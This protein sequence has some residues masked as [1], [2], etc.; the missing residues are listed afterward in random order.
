MIHRGVAL[1]TIAGLAMLSSAGA[2]D[3]QTSSPA[4]APGAPATCLPMP[5]D[6]D[7]GE[8]CAIAE[9]G[10]VGL[11][12][13]HHFHFAVYQYQNP[14]NSVL[15][16]TRVVVFET[17]APG[18]VRAV[19]ATESDPAVS[20]DEPR[21]LRGGGRVLLHIPGSESGTGN[22]NRE[23]LFVWR[24]GQWRDVDTT[25]WLDDLARRLPKGYGAWKGI[26]PDYVTLKATTPLW[27]KGD[28]NACPSG[29][30]A[31]LVLGWQG[32]RIV[33]REIR[34]RRAA[35]CD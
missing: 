34:R 28:G 9:F 1:S 22:L 14:S 25:A 29:G 16:R 27:R 24:A 17:P 3:L 15:N 23:R 11:V 32:D 19:A 12:D 7:A 30:R 21:L 31:D 10:D 26:Y 6:R 4:T 20:Y 13:D 5:D 8:S 18:T 35:E 2:A 33:L